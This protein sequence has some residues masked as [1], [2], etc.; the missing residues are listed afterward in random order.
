MQA[1]AGSDVPVASMAPEQTGPVG[2][3]EAGGD[4][5]LRLRAGRVRLQDDVYRDTCRARVVE[6][7]GS[8][9]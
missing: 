4:G 3:D 9:P 2:W 7:G 8:C 6:L 5:L 1:V